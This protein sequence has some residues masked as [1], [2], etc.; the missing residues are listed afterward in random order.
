MTEWTSNISAGV[1]AEG[2]G[3]PAL[4][5]EDAVLLKRCRD[6]EMG[7]FAV[8]IRK[9]QDRLYN[10]ILKMCGNPD[11]AEELCQEAFVKAL[12]NLGTFRQDSGFYTW[13][14]RIGMN[15][16]I[17]RRR[18]GGRVKF[19]SLDPGG[20]DDEPPQRL[21]DALADRAQRDPAEEAAQKDVN[22]RVMEAL[23]EVEDDFRAVVVLRDIEEM[24]YKQISRVLGTPVGTVKSRLYRAR[25]ML[26]ESLES[27]IH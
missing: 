23:A 3:G 25:C 14:F 15:L 17:S 24:S 20:R 10:A 16:T 21:R 22:R 19:H 27:L 2:Q 4:A 5:F 7:G 1:N 26:K 8:L 13:L 9:Y 6:G 18:K 11:D 12:E